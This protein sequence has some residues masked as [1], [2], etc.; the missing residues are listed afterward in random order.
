MQ[1][2]ISHDHM[3]TRKTIYVWSKNTLTKFRYLDVFSKTKPI[4][5]Q[6]RKRGFIPKAQMVAR[7]IK[8]S[9]STKAYYILAYECGLKN[10]PDLFKNHF[11]K[12]CI[13]MYSCYRNSM[14]KV[15]ILCSFYFI[16]YSGYR[17]CMK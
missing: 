9:D 5:Q 3:H 13:L 12:F 7:L 11:R 10:T 17:N 16:I 1:I 2:W 6:K 14:K 4:K 8:G 15:K